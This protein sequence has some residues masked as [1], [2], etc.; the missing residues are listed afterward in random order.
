MHGGPLGI[1]NSRS[2]YVRPAGEGRHTASPD[3]DRAELSKPAAASAPTRPTITSVT[4]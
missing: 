1:S 2:M 3:L 4:G